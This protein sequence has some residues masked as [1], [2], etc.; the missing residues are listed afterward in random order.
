MRIA[1]LVYGRLNKCVEHYDNLIKHVG[2][3]HS[4]DFFMS[5]DNSNE[6]QLLDFIRIYNPVSYI[7]DKIEYDC[8]FK[9]Y[10]GLRGE[11]NIHNMTC[12]FINKGRV[13]TLLEKYVNETNIE[14]DIIISLRIDLIF[15]TPFIFNNIE[16]NTIY[17]PEGYDHIENAINDQIAYGNINVMKKYMN[18]FLNSI[19]L[20]NMQQCIPHPEKLTLSNIIFNKL[21]IFR[22][23]LSYAI[24]R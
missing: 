9:K 13:F 12:H 20:L 3:E 11:T 4:I 8:D 24:E 15:Y 23:Y 1:I 7:N 19:Y 16:E 17:I 5:S 10:N 18:I 21:N 2:N 14:Y 22:F 6:E